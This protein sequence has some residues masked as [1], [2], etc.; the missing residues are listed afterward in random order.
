VSERI[1]SDASAVTTVTAHLDRRGGMHRPYLRLP[2]QIEL[3]PEVVIRLSLDGTQYFT[4]VQSDRDGSYIGGAYDNKRIARTPTE[5]KN[6]LEEW[7]D[8]HECRPGDVVELD[9][10]SPSFLYGMREPGKRQIYT[11]PGRPE[12][13]LQDIATKFHDT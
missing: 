2:D 4:H 13:S 6:R 5:G 12:K 1:P 9:I 7:C 8:T 3:S 10:V 11:V